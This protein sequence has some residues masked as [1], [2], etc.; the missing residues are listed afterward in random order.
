MAVKFNK[1]QISVIKFQGFGEFAPRF[2]LRYIKDGA[3]MT[4]MGSPVR[5]EGDMP[6][7][8]AS[9]FARAQDVKSELSEVFGVE[10][11]IVDQI[12]E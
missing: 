8:L 11:E 12:S 9:I 4:L 7:A 10:A 6:S 5:H 3:E 2:G 1:N